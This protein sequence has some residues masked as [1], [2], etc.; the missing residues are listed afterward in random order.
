MIRAEERKLEGK[1]M[2]SLEYYEFVRKVDFHRAL[3]AVCIET[4]CFINNRELDIQQ[5]FSQAQ[6]EP[7]DF[8]K[9]INSFVKF[10]KKMPA[11]LKEHFFVIEKMVIF[12]FA[13]KSGSPL[14]RL[15]KSFE[16]KSKSEAVQSKEGNSAS[17]KCL[18][19]TEIFLNRSE[20]VFFKKVIYYSAAQILDL[21]DQLCLSETVMENVWQ[22][23]TYILSNETRLLI[24][25]N[26]NHL[27]ICAIY[28]NCKNDR[29]KIN[30]E[31]ILQ[32]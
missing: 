9:M 19:K 4:L 14:D 3:T 11:S 31:D 6:I 13:W 18:I 23:L 2:N 10:D 20:E 16:E 22:T 8:W 27:I 15:I 1:N 25:R 28:V 17:Q 7:F 32:K 24:N 12:G 26:I 5:L 29:I 30:F 21:C